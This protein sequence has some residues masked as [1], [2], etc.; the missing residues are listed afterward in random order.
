[1][2]EDGAATPRRKRA[3]NGD[4]D[5]ECSG[6]AARVGGRRHG[7]RRAQGGRECGVGERLGEE[8]R[9]DVEDGRREHHQSSARSS[10]CGSRR[11]RTTCCPC[12]GV[13]M[14]LEGR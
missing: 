1:V 14:R 12:G 7:G 8:Q 13:T 11:W 3:W 4:G 9:R 10:G 6:L 2:E 5:R